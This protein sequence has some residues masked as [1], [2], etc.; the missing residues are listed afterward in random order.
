MMSEGPYPSPSFLSTLC[1]SVHLVLNCFV[2][3]FTMVDTVASCGFVCVFRRGKKEKKKHR[4]KS[5]PDVPVKDKK[6]VSP[7]PEKSREH[8]KK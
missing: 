6:A 8:K 5:P 2:A 1:H 3:V 7:I 4:T